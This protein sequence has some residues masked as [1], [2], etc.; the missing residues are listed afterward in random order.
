MNERDDMAL[1]ARLASLARERQPAR[2]LWP[3]IAAGLEA[4]ATLPAAARIPPAR[5]RRTPMRWFGA[6]LAACVAAAL[7]VVMA[8]PWSHPPAPTPLNPPV[9]TSADSSLVLINA[10]ADV[11][12]LARHNE[13]DTWLVGQPGGRERMAAARELDTSM[14]GLAAALR[15]EPESQ[16]LRRL[17]HQ[18]LQ[19]RIALMRPLN[20]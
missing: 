20:A 10:Y 9:A 1:R 13:L 17:L 7:I 16:L 5:P 18:T 19:Q 14:A 2:D 3:S 11:L 4:R 12:D 8:A 6:G 15:L